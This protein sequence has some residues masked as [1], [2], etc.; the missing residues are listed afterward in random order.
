MLVWLDWKY[1]AFKW[2]GSSPWREIERKVKKRAAETPAQQQQRKA[3]RNQKRVERMVD[4][5]DKV[6][7]LASAILERVDFTD[8]DIAFMGDAQ[9]LPTILTLHWPITIVVLLIQV[10]SSSVT[11][12]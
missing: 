6:S 8:A 5:S 2:I 10:D 1:S 7:G 9:H 3:V 4:V 11:R 12:N